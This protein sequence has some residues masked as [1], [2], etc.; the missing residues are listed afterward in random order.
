MKIAVIFYGPPGSGKGTQAKLLADKLDLFHFDT[1]VYLR[2]ILYEPANKNNKKIQI[3]RN[4]NESGKLNT[5]EWVSEIIKEQVEELSKLKQSVVFSGS[6]RTMFEA[7]GNDKSGGLMKELEKLYGK[8][9]IYIFKINVS[10]KETIKRNA[11]RLIC[12]VCGTPILY[13]LKYRNIKMSICPFCGG[14][15]KHRFD[16]TKNVIIK[17]LKEYSEKTLPVIEEL[18]KRKYKVIEIN[19]GL[20]PHKIHQRILSYFKRG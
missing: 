17:R 7:F 3:E 9:N 11:H 10:E 1:G 5:P 4:L 19:G 18:K 16:D 20:M 8:K 14:S 2:K 12:S 13:I 15:L 6:P